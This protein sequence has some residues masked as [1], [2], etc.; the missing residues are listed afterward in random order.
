MKTRLLKGIVGI[1]AA[2]V[3]I[4]FVVVAAALAFVALNMGFY[5]TQRS[6]EVMAAGL[7]QASSSLELDGSV[8]AQVDTTSKKVECIV[9]PIRLSAGQ[10]EVD[11]TP[12]KTTI[13]LWIIG[14]AAFTNI[15][16]SSKQAVPDPQAS[17]SVSDLCGEAE[18]VPNGVAIIWGPGSNGDTVLGPGEKAL[19]VISF[20]ALP[21]SPGSSL[22]VSSYDVIKVEIKPPL[23]AALTVER[24]VPASLTAEI[25][26]FG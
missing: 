26:D 6:K 2:I 13:A 20:T 22:D 17:Y 25:M 11:L 4:A 15:Y 18:G 12:N 19:V 3:L 8:L 14:K 9:I 24:T 1:E 21:L 23:G 10:K 5:T 16:S 7:A